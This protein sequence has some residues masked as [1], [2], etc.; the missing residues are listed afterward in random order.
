MGSGFSK[1]KKQAKMMQEEFMKMQ[2]KLKDIEVLGSS[3]N[4]LVAI[5]MNGDGDVTKIKINPEC[6]DPDDIEG[7]ED[8]IKAAFD[9]AQKKL[10][11]ETPDIS[12]MM[13]GGLPGPLGSLG[14][15]PGLG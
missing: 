10:K 15:F 4:G 11:K 2:E 1:R 12:G 6:V 9:D 7:L 3:G 13:G 14:G 5:S 8:L